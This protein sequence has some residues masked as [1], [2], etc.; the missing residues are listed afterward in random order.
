MPQI[1][2][3]TV[4]KQIKGFKNYINSLSQ[5][6]KDA[7]TYSYVLT[8]A[9]IDNLLNQTGSSTPLDGIR[10]YFGAENI[11]G[12]MVPRMYAVG[13]KLVGSAYEDYSVPLTNLDL[14]TATAS[15]AN[16]AMPKKSDGL[17]CPTYCSNTNVLNS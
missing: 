9:D 4:R 11:S 1:E 6:A 3:K 7:A 15:V 10:I 17:P 13:S 16:A 14:E 2:W 8:A 12:D 5:A